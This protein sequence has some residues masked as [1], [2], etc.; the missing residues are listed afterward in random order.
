V[1]VVCSSDRSMSGLTL[2]TAAAAA[3]ELRDDRAG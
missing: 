1:R 2:A 3:R